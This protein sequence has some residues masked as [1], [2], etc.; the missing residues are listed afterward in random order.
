MAYENVNVSSLKYSLNQCLESLSTSS[1]QRVL[2]ELNRNDKWCAESKEK[3]KEALDKLINTRYTELKEYLNQ[4]L[5]N[6]DQIQKYQ[7]ASAA[8]S[9]YNSQISGLNR[10]LD[11]LQT[12][13]N[14]AKSDTEK[15]SI[16][17]QIEETK[18]KI[19]NLESQSS[20]SESSMNS[21]ASN[22]II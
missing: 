7:E 4:C 22:I 5:S 6:A 20:S 14:S 1:S 3:Y 12:Q 8:K 19:S 2:E 13:K 17:R 18:T 15:A 9:S 21:I 10:Q 11:A 16:Q